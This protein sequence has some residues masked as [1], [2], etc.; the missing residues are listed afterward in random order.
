LT[1]RP[2]QAVGIEVVDDGHVDSPV[3]V[4]VDIH[5]SRRTGLTDVVRT[6][7]DLQR[8]K[9]TWLEFPL[10][11][12]WILSSDRSDYH[13]V[14]T[15]FGFDFARPED[16]KV[17]GNR[18][19]TRAPLQEYSSVGRPVHSPTAGTVVACVSSRRD[20]A[21]VHGTKP[22]MGYGALP[23]GKSAGNH[24]L[25]KTKREQFVLLAHMQQGS[26]QVRKGDVVSSGDPLGSVGN[27]GNT[28][29][30]HLHIEVMDAMPDFSR[31]HQCF[32]EFP[33]GLPFGFRDVMR[34][35]GK[36]TQKMARCV[37]RTQDIL[38]SRKE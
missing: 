20:Y 9:T 7:V 11:G 19:R 2:K 17:F 22:T 32:S 28:I 1:L 13:C 4:T 15:Q 26:I 25:V 5:F 8:R 29:G 18:T 24:V 3:S 37:P 34:T 21:V 36:S 12:R 38:E 27:S 23:L 31:V 16:L 10:L 6:L 14:G 35:R 33:S 30:P